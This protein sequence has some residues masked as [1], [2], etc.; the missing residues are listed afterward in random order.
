MKFQYGRNLSQL[1]LM[2]KSACGLELNYVLRLHICAPGISVSDLLHSFVG[3]DQPEYS[4]SYSGNVHN[5]NHYSFFDVLAGNK[6]YT[7][8]ITYYLVNVYEIPVIS[9]MRVLC[10]RLL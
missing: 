1:I 3:V 5:S 6:F 2:H 9:C 4:N 7:Y 10:P 8:F